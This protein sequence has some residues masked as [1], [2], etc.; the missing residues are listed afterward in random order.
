MDTDTECPPWH[1]FLFSASFSVFRGL[2]LVF[3]N[4]SAVRAHSRLFAA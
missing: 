4:S 1:E 3:P 2:L